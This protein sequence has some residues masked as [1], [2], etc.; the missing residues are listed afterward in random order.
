L[1]HPAPSQS[2]KRGPVP[3]RPRARTVHIALVVLAL[4]LLAPVWAA[5]QTFTVVTDQSQASYSVSEKVVGLALP[6]DAVGVTKLVSGSIVLAADG[7]V[8]PGSKLTVDLRGLTSDAARRDR[9]IQR[10]TLQTDTYPDAVLVP[11]ALEGLPSPLPT[12]GTATFKIVGDLTV[13]GTTKT[14]TWDATAT[15]SADAVTVKATTDVT[16][17]D[18]GLR[19]PVVG[20]IL[21]VSDP[22]HLEVDAT[23]RPAAN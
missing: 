8:S 9:F 2:P 1:H 11:T 21:A 10:N 15:F 18:F 4:A 5:A 20:P 17:D 16:F 13:H 3:R 19:R 7:T 14:V 23:L 22:I 6:R 12:S